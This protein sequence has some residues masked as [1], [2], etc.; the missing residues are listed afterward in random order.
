MTWTPERKAELRQL[1]L[2]EGLSA[3][4][5]AA[6]MGGGISRNAVIG[7]A[8]RMGLSRGVKAARPRRIVKRMR[9]AVSAAA[10]SVL[11]VSVAKASPLLILPR[12]RTPAPRAD[13]NTP[14]PGTVPIGLMELTSTTCRWPLGDPR[15]EGFGFCARYCE[16]AAPYCVDHHALAFTKVGVPNAAPIERVYVPGGSRIMDLEAA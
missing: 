9:K 7:Q 16:P 12:M 6:R 11:A 3:S 13:P 14:L 10:K 4:V 15:A 5:V 8:S 2:V 1:W